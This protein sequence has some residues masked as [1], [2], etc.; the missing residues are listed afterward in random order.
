M[1][2]ARQGLESRKLARLEIDDRLI[3]YPT[4]V[5]LERSPEIGFELQQAHGL[6]V[7]LGV[8]H[9]VPRTPIGLR[10]IHG[11][12]GVA[13]HFVRLRVAE[14]AESDTEADGREYLRARDLERHTEL[15]VNT[16]RNARGI[17]LA[18]N[19]LEQDRKLVAAEPCQRIAR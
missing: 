16:I 6:S 18:L 4:L 2:P 7:H 10:S 1:L 15:F 8:E 14:A 19:V 11:G 17:R 5:A 13:Q 3:K 12:V 9:F